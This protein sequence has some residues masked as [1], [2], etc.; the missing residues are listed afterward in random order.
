MAAGPPGV[1]ADPLVGPLAGWLDSLITVP[2]PHSSVVVW[3]VT[4]GLAVGT[5]P[6]PSGTVLAM[7]FAALLL[8]SRGE[9]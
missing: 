5:A 2:L 8:R 1:L 7:Y 6:R 4:G 9:A 3:T